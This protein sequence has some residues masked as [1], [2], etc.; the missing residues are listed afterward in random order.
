MNNS[1]ASTAEGQPGLVKNTGVNVSVAVALDDGLIAPVIKDADKKSIGT[2]AAEVKDLAGRAREGKIKQNELEGATFQVTNL[3]M[4]GVVEFGSFSPSS[5]SSR[6]PRN[7]VS[8]MWW[9]MTRS[10][11]RMTRDYD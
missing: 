5:V 6:Q 9:S 8:V 3:G 2:I 7:G 11:R 1:F 4:Y 10:R